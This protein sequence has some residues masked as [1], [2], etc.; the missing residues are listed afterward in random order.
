MTLEFLNKMRYQAEGHNCS[1]SGQNHCFRPRMK[2]EDELNGK[3]RRGMG[4]WIRG[5]VGEQVHMQDLS[6]H[7]PTGESSGITTWALWAST[8]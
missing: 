7:S 2:K 4:I 5:T 6:I 3:F 1:Q 8:K